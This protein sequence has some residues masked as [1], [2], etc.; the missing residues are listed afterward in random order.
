MLRRCERLPRRRH[1]A[2][3]SIT[4]GSL[5]NSLLTSTTAPSA[6]SSRRRWITCRRPMREEAEFARKLTSTVQRIDEL[7][8]AKQIDPREERRNGCAYLR[9]STPPRG[10]DVPLCQYLAPTILKASLS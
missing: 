10:A 6:V 2:R 9:P 4:D 5:R 1:G 7:H 8:E 3:W